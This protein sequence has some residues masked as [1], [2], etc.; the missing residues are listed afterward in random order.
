MIRK[1]AFSLLVMSA[2]LGHAATH[3]VTS[4][5]TLYGIANQYKV[6]VKALQQSNNLRSPTIHPGQTLTIPGKGATSQTTSR[7]IY[8]VRRGDTLSGI[9]KRYGT[10][11]AS[12]RTHNGLRNYMLQPGQRLR[13]PGVGGYETTASA[14]QVTN[15]HTIRRGDTLSG[16][17]TR[18][19]ISLATLVRSNNLSTKSILHPGDVLTIPA[20]RHRPAGPESNRNVVAAATH[21]VN[22]HSDNVIVVDARSGK[23]LYEKN[24]DQV[25]SIASITK[26]MTAMVTLDAGLPMDEQLTITREDVDYLKKTSSRL[27]LGTTMSRYE[28]LRLALMSSENRAA[29]ALSRHYPGGHDAFI[30]AMN[31]K[32]K[33]LGMGSTR[34]EDATGLTPANVSTAAD[35]VKMVGAASNYHLIRQFTTTEGREVAIAKARHLQYLN[36]NPLVRKGQWDIQVSKTGYINEAG[37]CLVMQAEVADRPAIMVFLRAQGKYTPMADASR[38]RQ[39]IESGASGINIASL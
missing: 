39:W 30:R 24:A 36:S 17:A 7:A 25:R 19:G 15:Q 4:G 22:V 14:P 38:V 12:L 29:S 20:V 26:L 10:S 27:P 37:R 16:I 33:A 1:L 23:T 13:I 2:S 8:T 9:A 11:V 28:M 31:A 18:Y 21:K 5:D 34:F 35:L 32:A 3:T 6:S